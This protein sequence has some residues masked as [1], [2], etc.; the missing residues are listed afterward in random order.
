MGRRFVHWRSPLAATL[1]LLMLVAAISFFVTGRINR[2]EEETSFQRL[3]EEAEEFANSL[4]LNMRSDREQLLL[5]AEVIGDHMEP[6]SDE[7]E[8]FLSSCRQMGTFFS[9]LELLLPGDEVVTSQG[10]HISAS[11]RLSFQEESAL[12]AHISDR[13]LDWDDSSYIVRHFVPVESGGTVIAMLCGV[14]ELGNLAKE[15]PYLPYGG[16]AA[17]YL[18]DG[19]TGDFLIDSWHNNPGGNIWE[20]GTRSMAP[21]YNDAQLRQGLINGE[22]NYVVFLSR[23]TGEYL[24]FYYAPLNINQWRV[25][26]S[27][28]EELVFSDARSIR[29]LLNILLVLEG[30]LFLCYIVWMVLYVRRETGEKQRQVDALSYISD[31]EQLLFN[32]HEHP[33]NVPKS[34]EIIARMLSARRVAFTMLTNDGEDQ[35]Y[36]WEEGGESALGTGL[37]QCSA[38]LKRRFS[39]DPCELSAHSPQE[40]RA[41]LPHVPEGMEDLAAIPVTD[42]G[43]AL[44]GILAASGLARRSNCTAM[45]KSVS[46]SFAMLCSNIRTYRTMQRR[47]ER[48]ALTGLYNRSR[49]ELELPRICA[50]CRT[51]LCCVFVDVNGLHELNNSAGHAA[52]DLMLRTVASE[53][54]SRFGAGQLYRLGGDEF[55]AFCIDQSEAEVNGLCS[56]MSAALERAGYHVSAGVA[57]MPAPVEDLGLLIKTAEARMYTAKQIFY[58]SPAHN[59]RSR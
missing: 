48:D 54:V 3:S 22:R 25:A 46:F 55:V 42:S 52:G 47:S 49:Y 17:L 12:G 39:D 2:A 30:A 50:K 14:I 5:I 41:L 10:V 45:L 4:E 27:V 7:A 8:A 6:C 57:W 36:L 24:Y 53:M 38:A 16:N 1:V 21:G 35:G 59:R 32:A 29:R 23:T 19:A 13:T 51:G 43:G 34:L 26:L 44:L 18:I 33:E 15:L 28:P 20:L 31:V 40:I 9:R 37:L 56:A 11:G 58:Q